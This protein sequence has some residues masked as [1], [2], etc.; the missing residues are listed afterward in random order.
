MTTRQKFITV[1]VFSL[2]VVLSSLYFLSGKVLIKDT[3]NI[4]D[5]SKE[6][7]VKNNKDTVYFSLYK[8]TGYLYKTKSEGLEAVKEFLRTSQKVNGAEIIPKDFIDN[9][10]FVKSVNDQNDPFLK[11]RNINIS[12]EHFFFTQKIKEIPIY[13]SSLVIHLRNK[14][15]IYSIDGNL[16]KNENFESEVVS[17]EKARQSA[18]DKA[19]K[20]IQQGTKLKV[21][22]TKKYI[23][24]KKILGINDDEKN[25]LTLEVK[26]ISETIPS[27]FSKS[28][29][30]DLKSGDVIYDEQHLMNALN[31][32]ISSCNSGNCSIVRQEGGSPSGDGDVDNAYSFF[33]DTYNFYLSNFQ[34]NSYDNNGAALSGNVHF[35]FD[36]TSP[37]GGCPNAAWD[38]QSQAMYFCSGM[39]TKDI[40]GHELT[41]AVTNLTANL[42]YSYQSGALNESVSDIFGYEV[43]NENWTMGEGSATGVIRYLDDPPKMGQPDRLFSPQYYC[44]Q[45]DTGG[46]HRN[47]GVMNKAFYLMTTGGN[48]NGCSVNGIGKEKSG[49]IVYYAL[50]RHLNSSSNFK[51]MANA[52]LTTCDELYSNDAATCDSVKNSL[53]ATEMDQQPDGQQQGA[54]CQGT[55]PSTPQ[56]SS[57]PN[58]TES[59]VPSSTQEPSSSPTGSITPTPSI[60]PNVSSFSIIGRVYTKSRVGVPGKTIFFHRMDSFPGLSGSEVSNNDGDYFLQDLEKG[61]Y[62]LGLMLN[63]KTYIYPNNMVILNEIT[64]VVQVDFILGDDEETPPDIQITNPTPSTKPI[65]GIKPSLQ[66]KKTSPPSS[67]PRTTTKPV[68]S[69][70][71]NP[72]G[73]PATRYRCEPDQSCVNKNGGKINLC[74]L[75][76]SPI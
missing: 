32:N 4:K 48:F 69:P 24:N 52:L 18:I 43:D 25:Y 26:V 8:K 29:F 55:Q 57:N 35:I 33:G 20:E 60:P 54:R 1:F 23:L 76:C 9:S 44:G 75:R 3:I 31:R 63:N 70:I 16:V 72:T 46:V 5:A 65:Q 62:K 56:C 74:P 37:T 27:I 67:I 58:P 12:N 64:P 38:G 13:S 22:G 49:S 59:P 6:S 51:A 36:P 66:P 45:A 39:A 28:Y 17:E 61:S 11:T 73:T 21:I 41:H 50:T 2:F 10:V 14:N 47:S 42:I 68:I 71:T 40:T 19:Y 53:S 30:V 34:R 7:T 15:E